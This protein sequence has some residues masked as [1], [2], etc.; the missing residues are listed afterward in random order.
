MGKSCH[1]CMRHYYNINFP[2]CQPTC[3]RDRCSTP[4]TAFYSNPHS[5]AKAVLKTERSLIAT[6]GFNS[7]HLRHMPWNVMFQGFFLS[8]MLGYH[9]HTLAHATTTYHKRF[10]KSRDYSGLYS[11][12]L[13]IFCAVFLCL[14]QCGFWGL[15][16]PSFL[17]ERGLLVCLMPSEMFCSSAIQALWLHYLRWLQAESSERHKDEVMQKRQAREAVR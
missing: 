15:R 11:I 4:Q 3:H 12:N 13:I 7:L 17:W 10:H 9:S 16:K 8:V 5:S 6:Q 14:L 1:F 2:S